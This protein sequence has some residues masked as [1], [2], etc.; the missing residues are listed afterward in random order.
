MEGFFL[1]AKKTL[2]RN[3]SKFTIPKNVV[4][5]NFGML[6]SKCFKQAPTLSVY[7]H[8]DSFYDVCGIFIE[9][10]FKAL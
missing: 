10:R 5:V 7:L 6:A 9:N 8:F 2:K 3:I 4:I 1:K